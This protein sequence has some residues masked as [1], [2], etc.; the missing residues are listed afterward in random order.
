[1][2]KVFVF[3][4]GGTGIR[5]MKSITMLA[6]AGMKTNGFQIVPII[7]DPHVDLEEKTKVD[8]LMADY[9]SIYDRATRNG[10]NTLE[11]MDGFF[12]TKFTSLSELDGLDNEK[13]ENQAERRSFGDYINVG[14]LDNKDINNYLIKTLY[15][16]DNLKNSLAVGFKG[17]P[18]VGTVVLNEMIE[19]SNWYDSFLRHFE[20]DDKVFIISSIF[21]GT[22]AS[23]Y[24]LIEKKVRDA[25]AYPNVKDAI[26]GAVTVLPYYGLDDPENTGSDIDSANFYTKTKAALSYYEKSVKSDY[27]YYVGEQ[28]LRAIYK[29]D[30]KEQKDE[31]HFVEL[32]AASALFDFLERKRP[33]SRQALTRAV[34]EDNDSMDLESLGSGYSEMVKRIADM[35]MLGQIVSILP[36]EK[37]FPLSVT[38]KMNGDFYRN[39]DF[40]ALSKFTKAFYGW[41]CEL[42][43][44][45]RSFSPLNIPG[46]ED[47][48]S[49]LVK[50][51]ELGGKDITYYLLEI[52]KIS[53]KERKTHD[54]LFRY[55]ME[56]LYNA[57]TVYTKNI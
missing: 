56:F 2:N 49:N 44:N 10:A 52:I 41:Y 4:I 43:K 48:F 18:N 33:D 9:S 27:L 55:L 32:V 23:G 20:K 8:N 34:R 22:G 16:E 46:H 19:K 28:N 38:W 40:N 37:Q 14:H 57:I 47:S 7:V 15:S 50:G 12:N 3:C 5:V 29:N 1:M 30:E 39:A 51:K 6:A 35:V 45:R 31:A 26:M 53:N 24:P 54:N 13:S 11:A 36:S 25:Q 17:N 21:G 42:A